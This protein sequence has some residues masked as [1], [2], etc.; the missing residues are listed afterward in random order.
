MPVLVC[1]DL[2][3]S[4]RLRRRCSKLV[5]PYPMPVCP[6]KFASTSTAVCQYQYACMPVPVCQYAS[7]MPSLCAVSGT[8]LACGAMRYPI[9]G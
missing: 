6:Y 5:G 4:M 2:Y 8:H 7:T 1:E 9:L 3:A